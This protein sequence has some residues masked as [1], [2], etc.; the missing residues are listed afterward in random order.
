MV[1]KFLFIAKIFRNDEQLNNLQLRYACEAGNLNEVKLLLSINIDPSTYNNSVFIS[2]CKY[3]HI[4]IVKLLLSDDRVNPIDQN[5]EAFVIACENDRVDVVNLLLND[6]RIEPNYLGFIKVCSLG[7]IA[8]FTLLFSHPRID[9]T[10]Q[11]S[12][13]VLESLLNGHTEISKILLADIGFCALKAATAA[14]ASP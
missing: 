11:I 6:V 7:H 2:A 9:I 8:T 5:N 12:K 10:E 14:V 3:G 4:D 1:Q 13:G